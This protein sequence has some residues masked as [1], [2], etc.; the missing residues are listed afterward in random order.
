MG[1]LVTID[2]AKPVSAGR[3]EL[4]DAVYRRS[5]RVEAGSAADE[6]AAAL[7]EAQEAIRGFCDADAAADSHARRTVEV[8][9]FGMCGA[10]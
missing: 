5:L 6:S 9:L 1:G 8:E 2:E 7:I 10:R 4:W 3:G